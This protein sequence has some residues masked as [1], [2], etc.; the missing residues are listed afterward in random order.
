M[1]GCSKPATALKFPDLSTPGRTKHLPVRQPVT[2]AE[3][4]RLSSLTSAQRRARFALHP[5]YVNIR[6]I[7]AGYVNLWLYGR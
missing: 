7:L 1:S 4:C 5:R 3:Y 2:S 6:H